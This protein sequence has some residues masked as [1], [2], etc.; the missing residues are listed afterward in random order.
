MGSFESQSG[1]PFSDINLRTRV[2][3]APNWSPDSST[4]EVTTI[5]LEFRD[6]SRTSGNP[7]YEDAVSRVS[8]LVHFLPKVSFF[9][10]G[11]LQLS[12]APTVAKICEYGRSM[13]YRYSVMRVRVPAGAFFQSFVSRYAISRCAPITFYVNPCTAQLGRLGCFPFWFLLFVHT[14]DTYLKQITMKNF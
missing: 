10:I 6:L 8:E 1:I 14:W 11:S 3:H 12:K 7:M 5:Q 2:G 13:L 4:S 9:V